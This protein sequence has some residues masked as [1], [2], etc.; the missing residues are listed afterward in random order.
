MSGP[1]ANFDWMQFKTYAELRDFSDEHAL[2]MT[3]E[4]RWAILERMRQL[5]YGYD[6]ATKM[7]KTGIAMYTLEE[8]RALKEKEDAEEIEKYGPR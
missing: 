6:P 1:D 4:G 7:E 3:V 8:F 5:R 2:E